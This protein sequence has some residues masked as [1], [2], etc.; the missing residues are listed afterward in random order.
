[1]HAIT[2][3]ASL[4]QTTEYKILSEAY[5]YQYGDR[6]ADEEIS[7]IFSRLMMFGEIPE[8]AEKF[9]NEVMTDFSENRK[10]NLNT[11]CL[12]NLSPRV[13]RNKVP[14]SFNIVG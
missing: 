11:Y 3:A 1:M 9:A 10:V 12:L 8:W 7:E 13:G 14:V 4:L 2:K 5:L 6:P